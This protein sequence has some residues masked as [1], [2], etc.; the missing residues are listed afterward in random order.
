MT[1]QVSTIYS[2]AFWRDASERA[3][4]SFAQG[5]AVAVG[6]GMA[7]V[8]SLDWQNVLGAGAGM[9]VM[10][11]LSSIASV[12]IRDTGTASLSTAVGPRV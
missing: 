6:G 1:D 5:A 8:L 12:G 9:A 2:V 10:S 7:N 11:L 3:Y 4:K